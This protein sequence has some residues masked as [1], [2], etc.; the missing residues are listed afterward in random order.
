MSR[1]Q[2]HLI[3]AQQ[4]KIRS[5]GGAGGEAGWARGRKEVCFRF[6]AIHAAWNGEVKSEHVNVVA[7]PRKRLAGS[8]YR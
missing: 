7:L 2:K 1:V 5:R 8:G 3:P 4:A 6:Y